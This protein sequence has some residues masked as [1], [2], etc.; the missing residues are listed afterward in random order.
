MSAVYGPRIAAPSFLVIDFFTG[1]VFM[2]T[3]WRQAVWREIVPLAASALVAAQ[4]GALILQ[5]A[6]A[7]SLRWGISV[8]V[9]ASEPTAASPSASS[10]SRG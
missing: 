6:D 5:Y 7:V 2:L 8:I 10:P 9:L 1:L 4:L 3:L